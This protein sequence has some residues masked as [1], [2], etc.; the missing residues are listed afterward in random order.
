MSKIIRI[1]DEDEAMIRRCLPGAFKFL[2][3]LDAAPDETEHDTMLVCDKHGL[4]AERLR[5]LLASKTCHV[6]RVP[7]PYHLNKERNVSTN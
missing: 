1:S 7:I 4:L 5:C 3:T 6:T 2:N